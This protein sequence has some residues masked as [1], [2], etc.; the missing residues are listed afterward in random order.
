MCSGNRLT[1][2]GIFSVW[3]CKVG[4][5][6]SGRVRGPTVAWWQRRRLPTRLV[7]SYPNDC[8]GRL[9]F[10]YQN[11]TTSPTATAIRIIPR[12]SGRASLRDLSS[13][14]ASCRASS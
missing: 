13:E 2:S 8:A 12:V 3:P 7:S 14:I 6:C 9:N 5:C 4:V 10:Y 1:V 11:R